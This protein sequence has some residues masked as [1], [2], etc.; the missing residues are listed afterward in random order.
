MNIMMVCVCVCACVCVCVCVCVRACVRAPIYV[1]VVHWHSMCV[2]TPDLHDCFI[3]N[4]TDFQ[5]RFLSLLAFQFSLLPATLS[6]SIL[7]NK[8]NEKKPTNCTS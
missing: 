8:E 4:F 7:H 3:F 5:R 2:Y 1:C 6:L